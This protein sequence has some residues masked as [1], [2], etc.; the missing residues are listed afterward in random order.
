MRHELRLPA[1]EITQPGGRKLVSFVVDGKQLHL[2]ATISRVHRSDDSELHG[3]QRPEVISHIAEIRR[4]LE[5]SGAMLPNSIVVAF[6]ARVRLEPARTTPHILAHAAPGV[7]VIPVDD[8]WDDSEK[9]GWIVDGQQRSA[10]LREAQLDQFPIFITGFV[11][12]NDDEQRSQ[13]IL[14]N[15][16]KPLPKGLIYELLPATTGVLSRQLERHRF[17]AKLLE[18]LN[19]DEDS[20]LR[21]LINTPTTV[22]G[23]IKDNS[24][25]RMIEHSLSDG[26]LYHLR[27][28]NNK[29]DAD[30]MLPPLK[31]FWWA[32]RDVFG[33]AWGLPPR[34]SRLMHGVGIV[35]L[36]FVMDTIAERLLPE[37]TPTL[38]DFARDLELL[39]PACS[40]T[41]G[42]WKFAEHEQRKWNELQNTPKDIKLLTN[43]L[44]RQYRI[45]VPASNSDIRLLRGRLGRA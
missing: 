44:L 29:A 12:A 8:A 42:Y 40:W 36:G 26:A 25:L 30:A 17:P 4:Y 5:S 27:G 15:S 33:D 35:S 19:Q 3:Y 31:L 28:A 16:T 37:Q 11:A 9:P 38:E 13:F 20:P 22:E 10:A 18:R 32:V 6:D 24:V 14:V 43:Y 45:R 1:I 34:R 39:K 2:F 21:S 7:L 23:V 41:S